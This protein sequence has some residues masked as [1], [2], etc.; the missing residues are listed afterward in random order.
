MGS[1][2]LFHPNLC[3]TAT[4]SGNLFYVFSPLALTP[5]GCRVFDKH[6]Q[7]PSVKP[8]GFVWQGQLSFED[9][10]D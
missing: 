4:P 7:T 9:L 2:V 8:D 6:W 5:V 3:P 1:G 10:K